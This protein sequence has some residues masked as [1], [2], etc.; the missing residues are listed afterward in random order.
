MPTQ[1]VTG[2]DILDALELT[3]ETVSSD[4]TQNAF[5]VFEALVKEQE[6]AY[7]AA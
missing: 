6:A 2:N 1:E 7:A 3:V 5:K 4:P